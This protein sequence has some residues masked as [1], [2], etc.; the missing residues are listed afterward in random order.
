MTYAR[1]S[2][3][4]AWLLAE[5][6]PLDHPPPGVPGRPRRNDTVAVRVG[7]QWRRGFAVSDTTV[8]WFHPPDAAQPVAH[9]FDLLDGVRYRMERRWGLSS[10]THT[11]PPDRAPWDLAPP[12]RARIGD[13]E[14][15]ILDPT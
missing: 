12:R 7:R 10:P 6:W 15:I 5:S 2:R 8:I 13:R 9:L 3:E 14:M 11:P 1:S 4:R